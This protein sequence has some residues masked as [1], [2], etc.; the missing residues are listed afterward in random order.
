LSG[1][2]SCKSTCSSSSGV[3]GRLAMATA[4]DVEKGFVRGA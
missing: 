2:V 3:V 4:V 1:L